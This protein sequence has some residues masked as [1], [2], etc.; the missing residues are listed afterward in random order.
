[1]EGEGEENCLEDDDDAPKYEATEREVTAWCS[2][3]KYT[4]AG[5]LV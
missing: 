4:C 2:C 3:C 5:E 1:M